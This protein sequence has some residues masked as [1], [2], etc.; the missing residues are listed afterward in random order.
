M[1]LFKNISLQQL[2]TGAADTF[3]NYPFVLL[4][5]FLGT[6]AAIYRIE[7]PFEEQD[8][9]PQLEKLMLVSALGLI[10][11][12]DLEL[13]VRRYKMRLG[14][15]VA[16]WLVGLVLLILYY[17]LLES[18]VE[19]K[20]FLRFLMLLLALHL[21]ASYVMFLNRREEN[22]FWQF[23]KVLFLR[24]L[25]A[26]LYSAVLFVGIA[27][28]VVALDQLFSV[29]VPD[30]IYPELWV[31][32]VGVF[33]TW[34]FLAGV[35]THVQELEQTHLYP[36][37]LKVFTQFVL[38]PLVS[39]YLLILYAYFG[40]IL[41][42]W[43]WPEGWVS[44]LVLCFAIAGI[45]SLLLI[46]PIRFEQGNNWIRIYARWF[47][48]ALFPLL[49]LLVLAIWRRISEYGIT[50]QRYVVLALA[51][52]LLCTAL[53]FL[54]SRSKN[55][56]FIPVTLSLVAVLAAFGP[57]NAFLVSERSQ[58]NRLDELLQQSEVLVGGQ[59]QPQHP[60]VNE[61]IEQEVSS[62]VDYLARY[63]DFEELEPWFQQDLDSALAVAT[64]S[65]DNRWAKRFEQRNVVMNL[66][67]MEYRTAYVSGGEQYLY[68]TSMEGAGARIPLDIRGYDYAFLYFDEG[69]PEGER[70]VSKTSFELDGKAFEVSLDKE[71]GKLIFRTESETLQLDLLAVVKELEKKQQQ[72]QQE[73]ADMT[74][75]VT[76]ADAQVKVVLHE[77][78]AIKKEGYRLSNVRGH[79]F[80]RLGE[81]NN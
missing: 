10:L 18:P 17:W 66:L 21:A 72:Y 32:M 22:A 59:V 48:R 68:F 28:A 41:V 30:D 7:L 73:Q 5:A 6:A 43:E 78:Q 19:E 52:W 81:Q 8:Q 50:E 76:G 80:V 35:P 75:V 36:K 23:N 58:V 55:I 60:Q 46:H 44:V 79:L 53:Y 26:A 16:L 37:G 24:I 63:H 38:L 77:L 4:S 40:K 2:W 47:Y 61:Q 65:L 69:G 42:Q 3:R 12:F 64:D 14:K 56:K 70:E 62:I 67:H 11:S 27:V 15:R 13:L 29:E 33:N 25:T 34:F 20:Q 51:F 49:I 74:F 71:R 31:F 57:F 9:Y 54:L 1:R 39:L 45:L